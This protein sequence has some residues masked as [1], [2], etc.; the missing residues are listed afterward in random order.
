MDSFI[1]M[2]S[3]PNGGTPDSVSS[4]KLK[5]RTHRPVSNRSR[6]IGAAGWLIFRTAHT[7]I[8]RLL[9]NTIQKLLKPTTVFSLD[10]EVLLH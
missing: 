3:D 2:Q 7:K 8:R 9:W 1:Q 6:R 4:Q 5:N 10:D